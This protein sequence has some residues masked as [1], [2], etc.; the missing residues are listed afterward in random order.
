[1]R[2]VQMTYSSTWRY[3]ADAWQWTKGTIT[4][5]GN[6]VKTEDGKLTKE[7]MNLMV[8]ILKP[9]EGWPIPN[10][11]WDLP[12]LDRY[13]D[14]LLS[15]NN[16]TDFD[17]VYGNR[18]RARQC[19]FDD[20]DSCQSVMEWDQIGLIIEKLKRQPSSRRC[21]AITWYPERDIF[22]E[23]APCLQ[24]IDFLIRDGK[25]HC[26]TFFRSWDCE[27]AAPANMY[28]IAKLHQYVA[29]QVG[30]IPGSLTIM[31][32]SAHIYQE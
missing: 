22:A 23:H 2:V 17:Y 18:L 14:Q 7:V 27:R 30:T 28:G 20:P 12:A 5:Y 1:M 29:S 6:L 3:P 11:E 13:A 24:L 32:A 9:L 16:P 19:L 15:S 4:A 10:S 8:T 25:L 26:T 31:A 21:I